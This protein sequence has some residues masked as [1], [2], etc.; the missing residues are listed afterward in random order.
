MLRDNAVLLDIK[1]A[2]HQIQDFTKGIEKNSFV[3]DLKNA[4]CCFT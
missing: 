2:C 1:N 4:I 3:E